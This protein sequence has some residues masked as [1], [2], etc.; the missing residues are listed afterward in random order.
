MLNIQNGQLT[1]ICFYVF[2]KINNNVFV[3]FN[4][5]KSKNVSLRIFVY[6]HNIYKHVVVV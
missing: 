6:K 4:K 2:H 3:K 1:T 5:K